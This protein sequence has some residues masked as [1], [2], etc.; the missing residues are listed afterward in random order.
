MNS[1]LEMRGIS[2][3]YTVNKVLANNDVHLRVN[4]GEIHALVGENGA[5]KT[6]L[7][8]ILDGLESQDSGDILLRGTPVTIHSPRDAM[9]L[10]IGMVH[11]HLRLI[12]DFSIAENVTLGREPRKGALFFNRARARKT[13]RSL[14]DEYGFSL[15]P[16]RPVRD[17]SISEMQQVEIV[18]VLY[19]NAELI[20]LDEPTTNLTE[21]QSDRLFDGLKRLVQNGKTVILITHK[22]RDVM[23]VADR[24]TVM[25]KG[26]TVAERKIRNTSEEEIASLIIGNEVI[27]SVHREAV[28]KGEEIYELKEVSVEVR[29]REEPALDRVSLDVH[30]GEILGMTGISGNGLAEL[31]DVISGLKAVSQFVPSNRLFRGVSLEAGVRD[32]LIINRPEGSSRWGVQ[33]I[34]AIEDF[35]HSLLAKFSI[36][37][38]PMLP[39]GYLSGGNIQKLILARELSS[40]KDF[41]LFS[42]PTWGLD[43]ASIAFVHG[44]IL[45]LRDRGTAVLLISTDL[46]EILTLSDRIEVMY[47]GRVVE[48]FENSGNLLKETIGRRMLGL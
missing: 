46:D 25:R 30:S 11:Q 47:M 15:D 36:D 5:G 35:T 18:K 22:L 27:R 40:M 3:L 19:R 41:I 43:A 8:K 6:T 32:N 20:I 33:L 1:F 29:G 7:M 4:A 26:K 2:K 42:D 21:S 12:S 16:S 31:E 34:K 48:T 38:D 9:H 28:A 17:L 13:V 39:A 44:E 24:V 23:S 10:G 37:T 45:K 14:A